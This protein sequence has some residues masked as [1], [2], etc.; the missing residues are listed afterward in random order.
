M[1]ITQDALTFDDVS[2]V[3]AHSSI[4]PRDVDLKTQL[5]R[6]ISLNIPLLSSA[7]DSV[8]EGR[9]AISMAQEGGLGVIHKNFSIESQASEVRLV[10]KFESG[11][12]KDPICVDPT[13]SIGQV[14]ELTRKKKYFWCT[15][16]FWRV[17]SRHCYQSRLTF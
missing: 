2:L 13:T 8:T 12:I 9:L 11:V 7:M 15:C 14:L 5:T 3:P 10:K 1:R 6:E 4:L 16:S 17:V